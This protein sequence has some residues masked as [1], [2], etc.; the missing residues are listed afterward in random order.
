MN[1]FIMLLSIG[2]LGMGIGAMVS[3]E[4]LLVE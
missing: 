3:E 2:A 1:V 4:Y